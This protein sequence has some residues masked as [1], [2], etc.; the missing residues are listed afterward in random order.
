MLF[1]NDTFIQDAEASVS[2]LTDSFM[3][4]YGVFST[5]RTYSGM[6]FRLERHITRLLESAKILHVKHEYT[7]DY[8]HTKVE[9]TLEKSQLKEARIKVVL[10]E[11]ELLI[12]P[13]ELAL[14]PS[15]WYKTG[16][17]VVTFEAQREFPEAKHMNCLTSM[18][19]QKYAK[20]HDVYEALLVERGGIVREGSYS[21]L[22]W[23]KDGTL[24]TT[25]TRVLRGVTMETVLEA[26]DGIM[27][28]VF[29][30]ATLDEILQA[31]ECFITNTTSEILPVVQIDEHSIGEIGPWTK[32]L[33]AAFHNIIPS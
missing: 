1:L 4:G 15:V 25:E 8:I 18:M 24:H 5:M 12:W 33:M 22:F 28:I 32:K 11:T 17:P 20:E 3:Y 29:K 19:A 30:D 2:P 16:I 7:E 9:E 6:I 13:Q 27:P 21:N 14:R 31:D 10:T 26:A 23:I